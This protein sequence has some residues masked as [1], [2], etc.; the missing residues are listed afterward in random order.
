MKKVMLVSILVTN[1]FFYGTYEENDSRIDF[2]KEDCDACVQSVCCMG[3]WCFLVAG[4]LCSCEFVHKQMRKKNETNI[5]GNRQ[6][7]LQSLPQRKHR[8][9]NNMN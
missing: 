4:V 5:I 6:Q 9:S 8:S 2:A 1:F 3:Y 7:S